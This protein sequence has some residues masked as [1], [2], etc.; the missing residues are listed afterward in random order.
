VRTRRMTE[1][2]RYP[3]LAPVPAPG[4]QGFRAGGSS[5]AGETFKRMWNAT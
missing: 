5:Q 4:A 1:R 3:L 2:W